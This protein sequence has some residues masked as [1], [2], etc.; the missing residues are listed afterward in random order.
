MSQCLAEH[1]VYA[2]CLWSLFVFLL[3]AIVAVKS[4]AEDAHSLL[5]AALDKYANLS[6]YYIKGTRESTAR[7]RRSAQVG[8][9]ELHAGQGIWHRV[10]LRH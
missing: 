7:E 4:E 5:K 3:V 1:E 9:G 6:T 8:T 10:S 2:M